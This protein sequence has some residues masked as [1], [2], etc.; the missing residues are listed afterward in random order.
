ML[1]TADNYVLLQTP[2]QLLSASMTQTT[3]LVNDTELPVYSLGTESDFY[4]VYGTNQD[5]VTGWYQYD[6]LYG[7]LQRVNEQ[8]LT[9]GD[10]ISEDEDMD[11]VQTTEDD[12]LSAKIA[13]QRYWIAALIFVLVVLGVFLGRKQ[14]R[15]E[16][17]DEEYDAEDEDILETEDS[18]AEKIPAEEETS[19]DSRFYA[20]DTSEVKAMFST[21]EE[22]AQ[23]AALNTE[24]TSEEDEEVLDI[25]AE[26]EEDVPQEDTV[27]TV[28]ETKAAEPFRSKK[29]TR[30][31]TD[32]DAQIE[33]LDLNNL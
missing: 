22:H 32:A 23:W 2:E 3:L 13:K 31:K 7:T 11:T 20:R 21:E 4:F 12:K 30:Y 28:K 10:D 19:D 9:T 6:S 8:L 14:E 24:E 29:D 33:I 15:D 26:H 1:G 18:S 17:Q 5:G 27:E 16:E 25:F